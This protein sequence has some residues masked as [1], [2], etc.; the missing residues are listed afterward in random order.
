MRLSDYMGNFQKHILAPRARTQEQMNRQ[1]QGT[2]YNLG[3]R[4]T[5]RLCS[6]FR[7]SNAIC[8]VTSSSSVAHCCTYRILPRSCSCAFSMQHCIPLLLLLVLQSL[9]SN[10]ES[11]S[12]VWWGS[13]DGLH[14]VR[15]ILSQL[16]NC[17]TGSPCFA[18][19][20][21]RPNEVG[22]QVSKLSRRYFFTGSLVAFAIVS[23]ITWASWPYDN[24]CIALDQDG[25]NYSGT[26]VDVQSDGSHVGNI[27][28]SNEN[29]FVFCSQSLRCV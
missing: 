19:F 17:K 13:G 25:N 8:L 20:P 26:Y 22:S 27:T 14:S 4:Y 10:M 5:V 1:F 16:C 24:L 9:S 18:Q 6:I 7:S 21:Q 11:T 23:S 29:K 3:E 28:V 15:N 2:F 12:S